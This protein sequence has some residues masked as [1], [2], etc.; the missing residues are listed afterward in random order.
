[1]QLTIYK[2]HKAICERKRILHR[3]V[4]HNN[5]MLYK[6]AQSGEGLRR[7]LLIDF[8]YAMTLEPL[9]NNNSCYKGH[10]TVCSSQYVAVTKY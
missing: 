6:L 3:D 1:M 9:V 5:I 7:G 10:R 4:S 2:A 8:D